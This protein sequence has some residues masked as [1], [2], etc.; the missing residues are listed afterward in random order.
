[1]S[2]SVS[3]KLPDP[4]YLVRTGKGK[5]PE[6]HP[7]PLSRKQA[8]PDQKSTPV[9]PSPSTEWRH[10]W[11]RECPESHTF[12]SETEPRDSPEPCYPS[13]ATKQQLDPA[14]VEHSPS[15][16]EINSNLEMLSTLNP[17][18]PVQQPIFNKAKQMSG[19]P[20]IPPENKQQPAGQVPQVMTSPAN[21]R[22]AIVRLDECPSAAN[23]LQRLSHNQDGEATPT[24]LPPLRGQ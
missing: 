15:H 8:K 14:S 18:L 7:I 5:Y 4:A 3:G 21:S 6:H 9:L 22:W 12:N 11:T 17:I 16:R 20:S 10:E 1:M 24:Q 2:H 13:T 23:P 19:A